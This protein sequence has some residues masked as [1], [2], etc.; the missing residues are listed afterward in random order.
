MTLGRKERA[1]YEANARVSEILKQDTHSEEDIAFMKEAYTGVGGLTGSKFDHG[2]FFTPSVVTEFV[3]D[4]LGIEGGRVL[5]PSCGGGAFLRALP[6]ACDVTG[7]EYMMETSEVARICYPNAKIIHGDALKQTFKDPFDYV[8]GNPPY[9]LKVEDWEFDSGKKAKSEIAFIEYGLRNLKEG[10]FL[11]MVIPDSILANKNAEPFRKYFLENHTLC[12]SISLPTQ[13]FYHGGTNVKTSILIIRKGVHAFA[14]DQQVFMARCS[15]IGWDSRGNPTGRSD[16][17]KLLDAYRK[18]KDSSDEMN[19][20]LAI[21]HAMHAIENG[22]G[23][24]ISLDDLEYVLNGEDVPP[25]TV[26]PQF[27]SM[28]DGQFQMNF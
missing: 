16:I 7:I 22:E 17:P 20:H 8:I 24:E 1:R 4:L 25:R 9:G 28:Q 27:D 15:D 21:A 2:Q 26:E 23:E 11:A 12:A 19:M 13:T 6:D 18:F 5:E 3:V 14:D 10:G